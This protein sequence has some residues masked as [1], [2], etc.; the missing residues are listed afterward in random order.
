MGGFNHHWT[1]VSWRT[2]GTLVVEGAES[3]SRYQLAAADSMYWI[4][5]IEAGIR[6]IFFYQLVTVV[7]CP[8][9]LLVGQFCQS[10]IQLQFHVQQNQQ[11]A[12]A[13]FEF[14]SLL[15]FSF[16]PLWKYVAGKYA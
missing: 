15:L 11:L 7:A 16:W 5:R 10:I 12:V 3:R 13:K 4:A 9:E 14:G 6:Y 8:V 2:A 1:V